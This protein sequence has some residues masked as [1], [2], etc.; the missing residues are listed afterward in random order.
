MPA[1]SG[2]GSREGTTS[3]PVAPSFLFTSAGRRVEL[4]RAFAAASEKLGGRVGVV[5]ADCDAL[6]PT[7]HLGV[8]RYL[9]PRL[10]HPSYLETIL[11]ICRREAVSHI[12]PL[13]DP[14]VPFLNRHRAALAEEGVQ[15][16]SVLPQ[17]VEIVE[18]KWQARQFFERLGLHT[19]TSW[20]GADLNPEAMSYP[21]FIKPRRGS[22]G[23]GASAV[24]DS[25]ELRFLLRRVDD[26]IVQ[27]LLPGPE[28]TCD[29]VADWTGDVFS[30]IQRQRIS[31]RGG[32]VT[33]GVTVNHPA[34]AEACVA[35]AGALPVSGPVTVQ[36][37]M[38]DGMPHFTEIN[39]RMG[40][41]I[42]LALA[43]G[44]PFPEWLMTK[45]LGLEGDLGDGS[46]REGVYVTRFDDGFF[47]SE[48]DRVAVSRCRL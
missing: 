44:V 18:D 32:E 16:C 5:V 24:R 13:I 40:G 10:D 31:V 2:T 8:R 12:F 21:L 4:I 3:S 7:L 37:L 34:V 39:G 22:A 20:R 19:P 47:I 1:H 11:G 36:C 33:K 46:Y 17:G 29:V 48:E 35:I 43:S 45:A 38:K 23:E 42:P 9:V 14:D 6:A 30:V 41:G 26:P 28:I 27:E 15:V 25:D